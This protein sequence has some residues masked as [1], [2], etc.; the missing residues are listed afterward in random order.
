MPV[1]Q[2]PARVIFINLTT[3]PKID[4]MHIPHHLFCPIAIESFF[5]RPHTQGDIRPKTDI[6]QEP[7]CFNSRRD[8]ASDL[9]CIEGVHTLKKCHGLCIETATQT[10]PKEGI[11]QN[12]TL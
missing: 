10:T 12:I 9:L 1:K 8:V 3:H 6:L 5:K 11:Y 4:D 7:I 2:L